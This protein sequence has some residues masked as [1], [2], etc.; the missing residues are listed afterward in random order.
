[1]S[2]IPWATGAISIGSKNPSILSE[3]GLEIQLEMAT[4]NKCSISA[5]TS[6]TRSQ[7]LVNEEFSTRLRTPDCGMALFTLCFNNFQF[8]CNI[9]KSRHNALQRE[10]VQSMCVGRSARK[11]YLESV[12][13]FGL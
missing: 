6:R 10:L 2:I 7:L 9:V 12:I 3:M 4:D 11:H 13:G 1:M 8:P 5:I